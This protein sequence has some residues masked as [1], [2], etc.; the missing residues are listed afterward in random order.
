M[1]G[2][3]ALD[4]CNKRRWNKRLPMSLK[5]GD[6]EPRSKK[7]KHE[8]EPSSLPI[9][10][11]SDFPMMENET[12]ARSKLKDAG[13]DPDAS[14]D[15][16]KYGVTPMIYFCRKGDIPVCQYLRSKGAS[17]TGHSASTYRNFPMLS[18]VW[19]D[20]LE[21][22]KWL[23]ENGAQ[24]DVRRENRSGRTPLRVA[25]AN[26]KDELVRWLVLHGA[27]CADDS[28]DIVDCARIQL[29]GF[30]LGDVRPA[31]ERLAKWAIT[32]TQP[33]RNP[34]VV[35]FLCGTLP[36]KSNDDGESPSILQYNLTGQPGIRQRIAEFAGQYTKRQVS[37]LRQVRDELPP[38][39]AENS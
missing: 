25:A 7:R 26:N 38:F 32:A 22:C 23:Y 33:I 8:V 28:S 13:F 14:V 31:L 20:G 27:L 12:T 21:M 17:T 15:D 10:V 30:G 9:N 18:A 6:E 4:R 39:L 16:V 3:P 35:A 11:A 34:S 1:L 36:P 5:V 37:I 29:R 2:I 19:A 24:S